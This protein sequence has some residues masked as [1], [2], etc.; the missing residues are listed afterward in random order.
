MFKRNAP[1]E[2]QIKSRALISRTD[3]TNERPQKKQTP[4]PRGVSIWQ[5]RQRRELETPQSRM[6]PRASFENGYN[7][8]QSDESTKKS[9]GKRR[10]SAP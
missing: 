7:K 5:M 3:V 10:D 1:F 2:M 8:P 6:L 4:L 9:H